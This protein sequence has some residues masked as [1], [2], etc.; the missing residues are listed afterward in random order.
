MASEYL[1][2]HDSLLYITERCVIRRT[3]EGMILEE[4]APGIDI[5]SQILDLCDAEII[6][7]AGG[8]RLMDARLF[9]EEPMKLDW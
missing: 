4:I 9:A 2:K 7:P 3:K 8:P 5:Q 6:I 1:K